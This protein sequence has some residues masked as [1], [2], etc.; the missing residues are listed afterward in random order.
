MSLKDTRELEEARAKLEEA[1]A[2]L[3][4][5]S[6]LTTDQ[7]AMITSLKLEIESL[8][9]ENGS[10]NCENGKLDAENVDL[11]KSLELMSLENL[12]LKRTP[13]VV[14]A[15]S[16][17]RPVVYC[18]PSSTA[19]TVSIPV[20]RASKVSFVDANP[21][22]KKQLRWDCF[23]RSLDKWFLPVSVGVVI[24]YAIWRCLAV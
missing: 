16:T 19:S 15:Q 8:N 7:E 1:K 17:T 18:T 20:K 22:I 4:R 23:C 10:L 3:E 11:V 12:K 9:E 21:D 13:K 5:L 14:V 24:I 6:A 2:E